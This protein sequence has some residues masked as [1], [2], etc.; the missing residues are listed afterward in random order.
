MR[1][2]RVPSAQSAGRRPCGARGSARRTC[3][4]CAGTECRGGRVRMRSTR[5]RA[6]A[7]HGTQ[8]SS[9]GHSSSAVLILRKRRTQHSTDG[10]NRAINALRRGTGRR[11]AHLRRMRRYSSSASAAPCRQNSASAP[12]A[13]VGAGCGGGSGR[14]TDGGGGGAASPPRLASLW[15]SKVA[16]RRPPPRW[17]KKS[18]PPTVE[19]MKVTQTKKMRKCSPSNSS[20]RPRNRRNSGRGNVGG[21]PGQ[22]RSERA[23]KRA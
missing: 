2:T 8:H 22:N 12:S 16:Q 19:R 14:K 13:V 23:Q 15:G 9:S 1:R 4:A 6:I 17:W 21:A 11:E 10:L 20:C 7:L 5:G 18:M 3:G